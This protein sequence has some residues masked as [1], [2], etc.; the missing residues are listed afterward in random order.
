MSN[1]LV[2]KMVIKSPLIL[3][4]KFENIAINVWKWI[5]LLTKIEK[6]NQIHPCRSEWGLVTEIWI[7][8]LKM[9]IGGAGMF[10][11]PPSY[12]YSSH[13]VTVSKVFYAFKGRLSIPGD[14]LLSDVLKVPIQ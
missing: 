3:D 4:P 8:D 13:T 5:K 6:K 14:Q 2:E 10:H 1:I 11:I 12:W 7:G 9:G